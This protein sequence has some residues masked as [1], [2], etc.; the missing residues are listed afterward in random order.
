MFLKVKSTIT[1]G[2]KAQ[3]KEMLL[4]LTLTAEL[5]ACKH[6]STLNQGSL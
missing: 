2:E 5:H 1:R 6:V 4:S 3:T